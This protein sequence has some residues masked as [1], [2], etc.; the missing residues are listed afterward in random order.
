MDIVQ[1][2]F[3]II[4]DFV[5]SG[6]TIVYL[7]VFAA[8]FLECIPLAGIIVPGALILIVSGFFARLDVMD[9][10]TLLA[11]AS[12]GA[13]LGDVGAYYLGRR[14][15]LKWLSAHE[16][17]ARAVYFDK[18]RQYFTSH[19]DKSV[20]FARFVGPFRPVIPFV[21]GIFQMKP[22]PFLFFNIVGGMMWAG[23][24]LAAGYFFGT[25]WELVEHLASALGLVVLGVIIA[26]ILALF[27]WRSITGQRQ[28]F[29]RLVKEVVRAVTS[30]IATNADIKQWMSNNPR[31]IN[32]LCRRFDR[33]S[34]TGLSLS[35]GVVAVLYLL[36]YA[37]RIPLEVVSNGPI[38]QA[39]LHTARLMEQLSDPVL[40]Q[41]MIWMT[42]FG[43]VVFVLG[44]MGFLCAC[45]LLMRQRQ[46]AIFGIMGLGTT[47]VL[48]YFGKMLI[49]RPRPDIAPLIT[50]Q[51]FSLPS[52]HAA[53]GVMLYG[54]IAYCVWVLVRL[55]KI[56]LATAMACGGLV[57][58]IGISR[59]YLGVH[60]ASDVLTGYALGGAI[61]ALCV[62]VA[63]MQRKAGKASPFHS[64]KR[65]TWRRRGVFLAVLVAEAVFATIFFLHKPVIATQELPSHPAEYLSEQQLLSYIQGQMPKH[66]QTLGGRP[67]EPVSF[68]L[69]G[70]REQ[71]QQAFIN[72]EWSVADPLTVETLQRAAFAAIENTS[73]ATA[74]ITPVFYNGRPHDLGVQKETD[75]A[76]VRQRHHARFWKT[77]IHLL[78]GRE[79]WVGTAAYDVGIKRFITHRIDPAID[80]ERDFLRDELLS[81]NPG[82]VSER[83]QMTQSTWGRNFT[84]DLFFTDGMANLMIWPSP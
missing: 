82:L 61:L 70:S 33:K 14:Y 30:A 17:F 21:A 73:Y 49:Q 58:L 13:I 8:A 77:S 46:L 29:M 4:T 84:G 83:I 1:Y 68:I 34:T 64:V 10:K 81:G 72:S 32:W 3:T 78:D 53:H 51:L 65:W 11:V 40:S 48:V 55:R 39:D 9:F 62:T 12:L 56:R 41:F 22:V 52:G 38:L 28:A 69:V 42:Q 18:A 20:L 36:W 66:T 25:S 19:G 37:I 54:W 6:G 7:G 16:R 71:I 24:F 80:I 60:W 76:S 15:G 75:R 67:Q 27:I 26:F 44:L 45:L 74:P 50:E 63:E 31:V 57:L 35:I 5:S 23:V 47:A 43:D 2:F 59:V 79:V